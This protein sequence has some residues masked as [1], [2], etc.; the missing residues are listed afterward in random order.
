LVTI[1]LVSRNIVSQEKGT[2]QKNCLP[3]NHVDI[4]RDWTTHIRDIMIF[5]STVFVFLGSDAWICIL[6][7]LLHKSKLAEPLFR[8]H[9]E[10]NVLSCNK[11]L[12]G[13]WNNFKYLSL[14]SL[15]LRC[16]MC[17]I[18]DISLAIDLH[19]LGSRS[20]RQARQV[21]GQILKA[22]FLRND[23]WVLRIFSQSFLKKDFQHFVGQ[24]ARVLFFYARDLQMWQNP[25]Q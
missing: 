19:T 11:I 16:C 17:K 7:R 12:T 25:Q 14:N 18:S 24:N 21:S 6:S 4:A 13:M 1:L 2:E 10:V 20:K 23:V 15:P 8:C 9:N 5:R 3:W 22:K